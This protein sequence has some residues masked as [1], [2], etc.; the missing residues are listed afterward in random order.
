MSKLNALL[1]QARLRWKEPAENREHLESLI[2]DKAAGAEL[3]V[4]PETFTTGF[5]GDADLPVEDMNGPTVRWMISTAQ[6]FDCAVAGS[7]VITEQ[8]RRFNRMVFVTPDG[9]AGQYDKRHLFAFGGE[10]K[11]YEAGTERVILAHRGWRINLQVCYDLRF[12]VWCRNRDDYDLMLLVANWPSRRVRHW[13]ALLEARAIENQCWVVGVN[14]VGR[15]GNGLEY[16]GRSV[17]HDPLGTCV[18]DLQAEEGARLVEMDLAKVAETQEMFP[19]LADADAF[20][21]P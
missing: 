18:A 1:V 4:L 6:R 20:T 11:H 8:G 5:L 17:V 3:V 15:D 16:P 2:A 10:N 9:V 14:R 12:P 19:F 21:L 7:A 13:S